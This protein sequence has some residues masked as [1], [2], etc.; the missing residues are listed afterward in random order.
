MQSS[1]IADTVSAA[2]PLPSTS[3]P[4]GDEV[5]EG[6][7]VPRSRRCCRP[8][9]EHSSIMQRYPA[10]HGTHRE[11]GCARGAIGSASRSRGL[12]PFQTG[13]VFLPMMLI[14]GLLSPYS[15]TLAQRCGPRRLIVGGM[16]VMGD[17]LAIVATLSTSTP[18]WALGICGGCSPMTPTWR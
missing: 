3:A 9:G 18:I 14:G 16:V 17:G 11:R 10:P 12:S 5:V 4:W 13:L 7:L 8:A 6:L 1:P 2:S 15:A